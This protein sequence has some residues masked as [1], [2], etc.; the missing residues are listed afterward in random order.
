MY[1]ILIY[2]FP[3]HPLI[4]AIHEFFKFNYLYQLGSASSL[5]SLPVRLARWFLWKPEGKQGSHTYWN[6]L[7]LSAR[8]SNRSIT[9]L[10]PN[11]LRHM[12]S[13][14]WNKNPLLSTGVSLR[15]ADLKFCPLWIK[16]SDMA[17]N[18][19][20]MRTNHDNMSGTGDRRCHAQ[21]KWVTL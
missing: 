6:R 10:D 13:G 9:M 18:F 7:L 4:L 12:Q 3:V 14:V 19:T 15:L 5:F 1:L 17:R 16:D 20:N 2:L 11:N 8:A 21:D